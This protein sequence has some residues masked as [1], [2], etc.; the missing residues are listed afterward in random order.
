MDALH[1]SLTR[2]L[3]QILSPLERVGVEFTILLVGAVFGVFALLVFK[4]ISPQRAIANTK[5]RIKGHLIEVRLYQDNLKLVTRAIGKVLVQNLRYLGLNILP[6]IPLTLPFVLIAS[7]LV[8]R[9]GFDPVPVVEP[10]S[11]HLAGHG[12]TVTVEW[13]PEEFDGDFEIQPTEG[14][15][16]LSPMVLIRSQGRAFQEFAPTHEGLHE[17]QIKAGVAQVTKRLWAGVPE[18]LAEPRIAIQPVRVRGWARWLWP[19]E[20]GL[21][22]VPRLKMIEFAY[23]ER[24]QGWLPGRGPAGV[25]LWFV[26]ASFVGGLL[27]I[28]PLKVQI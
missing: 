5:N 16:P 4:Y 15:V 17:F 9:Y 14:L 11:A 28:K 27:A 21:P 23:P 8:T 26:L 22:E 24:D 12:V 6:F 3:D 7:Q 10:Q 2:L 20:A 18:V 25:L 13:A 19:A 1:R